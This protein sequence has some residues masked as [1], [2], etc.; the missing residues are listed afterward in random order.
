MPRFHSKVRDFPPSFHTVVAPLP[1]KRNISS[2][3]CFVAGSNGQELAQDL[4]G[5]AELILR[6]AEHDPASFRSH[7]LPPLNFDSVQ[8]DNDK[9]A[10]RTPS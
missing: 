4:G 6:R 1:L 9:I 8:I 3:R 7:P 2:K 5:H 10:I